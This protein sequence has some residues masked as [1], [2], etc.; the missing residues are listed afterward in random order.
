M[1]LQKSNKD[2]VERAVENLYLSNAKSGT[3]SVSNASVYFIYSQ[4]IVLNK[5]SLDT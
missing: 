2:R 5:I 3:G 1:K 4:N